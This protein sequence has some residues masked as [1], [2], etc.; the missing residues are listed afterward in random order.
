MNLLKKI[1]YNV[2]YALCRHEFDLVASYAEDIC[3]HVACHKCKS[4]LGHF[5]LPSVLPTE[6]RNNERV[7]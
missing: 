4:H 3:L 1:F 6:G 2:R 5:H 7:H